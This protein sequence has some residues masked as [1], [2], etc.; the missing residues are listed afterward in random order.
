MSGG[1]SSSYTPF[2]A[3][4]VVTAAAAVA[5]AAVAAITAAEAAAPGRVTSYM[6]PISSMSLLRPPGHPGQLGTV[7]PSGP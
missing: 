7:R 4:I 6:H 1:P 5:A 2:A 3:A